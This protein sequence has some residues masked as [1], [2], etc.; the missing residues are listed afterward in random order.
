MDIIIITAS[1]FTI[2]TGS[3]FTYSFIKKRGEE[4]KAKEEAKKKKDKDDDD[5]IPPNVWLADI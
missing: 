4:K 1:I 2:F 5:H 3:L